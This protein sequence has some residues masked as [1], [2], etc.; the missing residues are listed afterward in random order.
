VKSLKVSP[1]VSADI[2]M[3]YDYFMLGGQAAAERFLRRYEK[4]RQMI[5]RHP[6]CCRLRPT[7]WRHLTI[8][9]SSYAIFY[10]GAPP[11]W[12]AGAVISIVQDPDAIQ[13][14]LFIREVTDKNLH[15]P[16]L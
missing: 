9:R 14:Q 1:A 15:D 11:C 12:V 16:E 8:P 2:L 5:E 3:A 10:R 13:A 7:G 4:A 6:E